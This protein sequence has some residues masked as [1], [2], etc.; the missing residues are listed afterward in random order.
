MWASSRRRRKKEAGPEWGG[1][2]ATSSGRIL[3]LGILM[4]FLCFWNRKHSRGYGWS[5]IEFDLDC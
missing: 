1:K 2:S 4:L 3:L 5:D